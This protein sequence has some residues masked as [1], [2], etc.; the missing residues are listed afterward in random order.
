MPYS[1]SNQREAYLSVC[2]VDRLS[3]SGLDL[4]SGVLGSIQGRAILTKE[5][6]HQNSQ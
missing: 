3:D 6:C 2:W 4:Y 1:D 5:S